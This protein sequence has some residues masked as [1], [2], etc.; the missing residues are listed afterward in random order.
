MVCVLRTYG[1]SHDAEAADHHNLGRP[2]L[3]DPIA[4][5]CM[6]TCPLL[7]VEAT[8]EAAC[9]THLNLA[10]HT[11]IL[12]PLADAAAFIARKLGATFASIDCPV[13][14]SM[15]AEL[16]SKEEEEEEEQEAVHEEKEE[17]YKSAVMRLQY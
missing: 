16:L 1:F 8:H 13:G 4:G 14:L 5:V 15:L 9:R 17:E 6:R 12:L 2:G 3:S 11:S 7:S 10:E